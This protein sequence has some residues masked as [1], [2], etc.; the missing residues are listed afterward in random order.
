MR[1]F[2]CLILPKFCDG[3]RRKRLCP[4]CIRQS[5]TA[6]FLLGQHFCQ[7][8]RVLRERPVGLYAAMLTDQSHCCI[9]TA[10]AGGIQHKAI[11]EG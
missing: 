8:I 5:V 4:F 6:A 11:C 3:Q 9:E 10:A 1:L 7:S 2:D